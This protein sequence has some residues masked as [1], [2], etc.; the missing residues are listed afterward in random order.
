MYFSILV[1]YLTMYGDGDTDY[2]NTP[3]EKIYLNQIN[4]IDILA[5]KICR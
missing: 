5:Y 3:R 4:L 2:T 1:I